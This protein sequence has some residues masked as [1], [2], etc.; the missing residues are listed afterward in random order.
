MFQTQN[1]DST[2]K[3]IYILRTL[4]IILWILLVSRKKKVDSKQD[5]IP[6]TN[7]LPDSS[8]PEFT[9]ASS[10]QFF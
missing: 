8:Q 9:A 5:R 3:E 10:G 4:D 6:R 2:L 7:D 1:T